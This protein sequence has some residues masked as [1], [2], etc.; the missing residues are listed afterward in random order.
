MNQKEIE[1]RLTAW[2]KRYWAMMEQFESLQKLTGCDYDCALLK[3]MMD[4]WSA[5]TVAVSELVGDTCEW[6]D[7]Y[8]W[9]CDMGNKPQN[10]RIKPG[11]PYVKIGT[12]KQ[13][14]KVIKGTS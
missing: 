3:P 14:A 9:E 1:T 10:V 11:D 13:L 5:Y 7:Y 4:V 8:Q 12:I 6:L 2:Q